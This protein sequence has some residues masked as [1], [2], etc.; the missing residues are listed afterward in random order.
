MDP[1]LEGHLWPDV[2]HELASKIREQLTPQLRPRYVARIEV[3]V[4]TDEDPLVEVGI[5]YPDIEIVEA[6]RR[7]SALQPTVVVAS[8]VAAGVP[9]A[10][11]ELPLLAPI[12][13]RVASVEIRDATKSELITTIEIISP[14]NK[15]GQG[16]KSYREKRQNLLDGGVHLLEIDLIRRGQRPL[17][18]QVIPA[19]A[20]R[21]TLTRAPASKAEI[22]P[23]QLPD[24][25]PLLP[26]PL[27]APDRDVI[28]NLA[29]ALQEVY[30]VGAYDLTI[31][32]TTPPPPPLL[33]KEE[34]GWLIDCLQTA[35]VRD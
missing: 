22:W 31:D 3:Y 24:P 4:V 34:Y 15:R 25:L 28:L 27:R 7:S 16:L 26:V 5:M 20:Y 30:E 11:F 2:H 14:V 13:V 19:S 35:G 18:Q 17:E 8:P 29:Q 9:P 10:P 1:Y 33:T 23:I 21:L 6:K 32:Y 12:P